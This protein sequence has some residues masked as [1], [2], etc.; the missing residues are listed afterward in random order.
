MK[1]KKSKKL[2]EKSQ[3]IKYADGSIRINDIKLSKEEVKV[4][5]EFLNE[6]DRCGMVDGQ[7]KQLYFH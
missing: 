4:L 2:S 7:A 3:V 1:I 5:I 6:S